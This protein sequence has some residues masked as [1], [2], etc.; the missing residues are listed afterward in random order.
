VNDEWKA[1]EPDEKSREM[2]GNPEP[3]SLDGQAVKR[4]F[5]PRIPMVIP[6]SQN[7]PMMV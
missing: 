5:L 7:L 4:L 3:A 1:E 6:P 2:S